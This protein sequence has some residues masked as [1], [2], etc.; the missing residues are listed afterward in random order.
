MSIPVARLNHAVLYVADVARSV[1]FY[2]EA[3][4]FEEV[5]RMPGAAFL[6]AAGTD[7]HHDLGLFERPRSGPRDTALYHLAWEVPRIE[8]LANA[9]EVLARMGAIVGSSDHGTSKSIY[10]VDPDGNEFEIMWAVPRDKWGAAEHS[11]MVAPLH[12]EQELLEHQSAEST[13]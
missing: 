2:Q 11:P 9:R 7:N 8:D 3:F 6:K 1:A 13:K 10:A 5:A 12:L 4:G